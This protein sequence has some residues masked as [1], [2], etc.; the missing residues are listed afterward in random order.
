VQIRTNPLSALVE[1]YPL[2]AKSSE[3]SF[4]DDPL[5]M[6]V[7]LGLRK[8]ESGDVRRSALVLEGLGHSG[9]AEGDPDVHGSDGESIA[10][11]FFSMEVVAAAFDLPQVGISIP[12]S[13]DN[14]PIIH[15][16]Y[17]MYITDIGNMG[18]WESDN[19]NMGIC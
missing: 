11:P 17:M 18:I 9:Q 3:S 15:Y 12:V 1:K 8:G 5:E 7:D 13:Y 16:D 19:W 14:I 2:R 10:Y 6:P 4:L